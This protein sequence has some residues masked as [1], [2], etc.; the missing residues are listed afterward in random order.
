MA[1]P[2]AS[3]SDAP[4]PNSRFDHVDNCEELA[5]LNRVLAIDLETTTAVGGIRIV[6]VGGLLI[7]KGSVARS[8]SYLCNPRCRIHPAAT[9]VHGISDEDVFEQPSFPDIWQKIVPLFSEAIVVAHK[10]EFD[11]AVISAELWRT[12]QP[13][14]TAEWWCTLKLAR[15]LWPRQHSSYRLSS[16]A[17]ALQFQEPIRHRALSDAKMALRLFCKEVAYARQTGIGN[18]ESLHRLAALKTRRLI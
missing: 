10:A 16:L 13:K 8:F 7:E 4:E 2:P 5:F 14:L 12:R 9:G 3:N 15:K 6:E 1:N 17:A 11:S 18:Y